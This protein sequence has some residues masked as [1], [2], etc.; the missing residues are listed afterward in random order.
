MH[1][2]RMWKQIVLLTALLTPPAM[3]K[4]LSGRC[5]V[6]Q[7]T[8]ILR[9]ETPKLAPVPVQ[10]PK[11]ASVEV[12]V[13]M[14]IS[15]IGFRYNWGNQIITYIDKAS[16]LYGQVHIGDVA[17]MVDGQTMQQS[18][19]SLNYF[20]NANS[21]VTVVV[22][23]SGKLMVFKCRR[24]PIESFAPTMASDFRASLRP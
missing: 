20:G 6:D 21:S 17:L 11:T 14:H 5:S 1:N 22:S 2:Y 10:P 4:T 13:P 8:P 7:G 23:R 9:R 12:Y 18:E 24:K 19:V 3:A 15:A 16:D